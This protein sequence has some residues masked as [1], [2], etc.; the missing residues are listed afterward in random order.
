MQ[1]VFDNTKDAGFQEE[2]Y[3]SLFLNLRWQ[4]SNL[5]T[6][7]NKR[8]V[9][10]VC[11][12]YTSQGI[13]LKKLFPDKVDKT[14]FYDYLLGRTLHR[15]R[16]AIAFVNL[17]L[18]RAQGKDGITVNNI[19]ECEMEYSAERIDALQYEWLNH[20]PKLD[21]YFSIIEKMPSQFKLSNITTARVDEFVLKYAC[22]GKDDIDPI[23]RAGH[24]YLINQSLHSFIISL[25]KVFFTVGVFGIKP[26][27]HTG[28]LW[29]Y[30]SERVP[31]DG[32]IKP[33]SVVHVHPMLWARLGIVGVS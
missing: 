8:V 25:T 32:Q 13:T 9:K 28:V 4:R 26:D 21:T 29:N 27:S 2:K 11:E 20:Y 3:K 10:F 15:P 30:L 6:L 24:S 17:C 16:D 1:N 12:P 19:K 31:S 22:D 5:I 33:T 7:I 18:I 14:D 23:I